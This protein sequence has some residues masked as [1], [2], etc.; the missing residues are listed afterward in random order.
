ML[1]AIHLILISLASMAGYDLLRR[2]IPIRLPGVIARVVIA[3]I[4]TVLWLYC[5]VWVL[6]GMGVAGLAAFLGPYMGV[7]P[8]FD[9]YG[10]LRAAT[11]VRPAKQRSPL[12][13]EIL[14]AVGKRANPSKVGHRI[15]AP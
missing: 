2:I 5:P 3:V 14:E 6:V 13:P 9:W 15:P 12:P 7:E 4:A 8:V 11:E 1:I 10:R